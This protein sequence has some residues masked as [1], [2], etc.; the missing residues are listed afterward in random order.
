MKTRR[1]GSESGFAFL[2]FL[3]WVGLAG[4]VWFSYEVIT[5]EDGTFFGGI[6]E[7]LGPTFEPLFNG[8]KQ[9]GDELRDKIGEMIMSAVPLAWIPGFQ[10]LTKYL[11]MLDFFLCLEFAVVL[12]F[13]RYA[14]VATVGAIR[15]IK[16]FLPFLGG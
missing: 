1:G 2:P 15:L 3:A 14:I 7:T 5:S 16:S 11:G 4:V 8:I 10:E 13:A 12:I 9:L 6:R